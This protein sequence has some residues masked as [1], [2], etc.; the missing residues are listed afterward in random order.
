MTTEPPKT[1]T[2]LR[3]RESPDP[4]SQ[5]NSVLDEQSAG[6]FVNPDF[7]FDQFETELAAAKIL[8][9]NEEDDSLDMMSPKEFVEEDYEAELG[10]AAR[11][12]TAQEA[13]DVEYQDIARMGVIQ[14]AGDDRLG[15]K[16]VVF[17]ACRLPDYDKV[18]Y[19]RL[20][21]YIRK[22]LEQYVANDYSLVYFHYGLTNAKKPP[23]KWLMQA[24]RG[25]DRNFKKNL[26]ALY[27]VHPTSLVLFII[28]FFK[29][30][31][32]R[33]FGQKINFVNELS[34]LSADM[35][36]DQIPIP[37]QVRLY[38]ADLIRQRSA[39]VSNDPYTQ[40]KASQ[41]GMPPVVLSNAT[42]KTPEKPPGPNQIFGVSL[43]FIMQNNHNDPIPRLLREC[44]EYVR[45]YCLD[46]D[47]IFR[48]SSNATLVKSIQSQY[49][50]GG[51]VNFQIC[52]DPHLPA[53]LIKTFLRD[54]SEPL[55]TYEFYDTILSVHNLP[56]ETK[57]ENVRELISVRL[58]DPNYTVLKYL[59]TLLTE[60]SSHS[61]QNRMTDV[62]LG[63]VFGPNLLWSRYATIS[64]FTEVGQ[65]TSFAQLLISSF[66]DIF[67]K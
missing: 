3:G 27:I 29:P 38:D 54:L 7:E 55:L 52:G 46:V 8:N 49:N 6:D 57:L 35:H 53:V 63:I 23:L 37:Q 25:F 59:M 43:D 47:G 31:I 24:Y 4:T 48:R 44:V 60:V 39:V 16:V 5:L 15:R 61:T 28:K 11:E 33:K 36:L 62:N 30:I 67:V 64:S 9:E 18:D 17:S 66:D 56:W 50:S 40:F 21:D 41:S 51:S 10:T 26:K 13:L 22:T 20:Y 12:V 19:Q 34:E 14:V 32:S 58:P 2:D 1:S 45:K 42:L 65:I